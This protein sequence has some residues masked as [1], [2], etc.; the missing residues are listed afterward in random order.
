MAR[1]CSL[2]CA[3]VPL[4]TSQQ[5]MTAVE[6]NHSAESEFS[7]KSHEERLLWP[8][9]LVVSGCAMEQKRDPP[10]AEPTLGESDVP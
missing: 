1:L 9:S 4:S 7:Q 8:V 5:S 2:H 10:R 6:S 3:P